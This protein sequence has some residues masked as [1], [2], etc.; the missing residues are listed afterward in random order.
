VTPEGR[1]TSQQSVTEQ[2]TATGQ[3]WDI[4]NDGNGPEQ[5]PV[6][7][8][9]PTTQKAAGD[10]YLYKREVV[11][12]NKVARTF[13]N[14]ALD[15]TNGGLDTAA[16]V[17]ATKMQ[18][19]VDDLRVLV[20]GVEVTRWIGENAATDA[21]SATTTVWINLTLSP[22]IITGLLAAISAGTPSDGSDLEVTRGGTAGFPRT[23]AVLVGDEVIEYDGITASNTNG[24]AAFLNIKR[25]R[26]N[27]TAASHSAGDAVYWATAGLLPR[28][29]T[30]T[31]SSSP[32]ST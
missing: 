20:D 22:G 19:D 26:R 25:G 21:N 4:V 31:M 12:A 1:S 3:S 14:Y 9:I 8:L 18:A 6:F 10:A 11:I 13:A 16:L 5:N 27:T 7:T 29:P 15:V 23:G 30:R 32:C 24:R 28:P 17:T 2:V